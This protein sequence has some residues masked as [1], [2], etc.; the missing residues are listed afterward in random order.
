MNRLFLSAILVFLFSTTESSAQSLSQEDWPWWRGSDRNGIANPDQNPPTEFG[1]EKNCR[2]ST[3]L[4]G[5]SH[6]SA[7][8]VGGKVFLTVAD[9]EKKTQSVLCLDRKT[10][11]QIWNTVVHRNGMTQKSNKKATWASTSPA[12]DGEKVYVNFLAGKA[13]FTTAFD[14]DGN[15]VWQTKISDYVVHQGYG[16]SPAIYKNL[17][18]V[19]ADNKGGGAVCAL[20]RKSG[21][22]IWKN[23]RP[24]EPNYPSPIILKAAG[25]DQLFLTGVDKVSSFDPMTGKT[26]WEIDGATT[27]CV[28]STVTDGERIFTSGGYPKN[29]VA[30]VAADGSG[31]VVWENK[32]RVYVPSMLVKD[33]YLYGVMDAGVAVCWKSA[34]GEEVWK[35]RLGGTFSSSPVLVGDKIYVGSESGEVFVY[36]ATPDGLT[37]VAKNKVAGEIFS[38]PSICGGEIFLRVA[39][40]KGE[41]RTE[42]L[43]CFAEEK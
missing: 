29:H 39:D 27:E 11:E 25:K 22:V 9:V 28:T 18:I 21:K 42:T 7:I 40:Y 13:V 30:A 14:M 10:G 5:R 16:S 35:G 1:P 37:I 19:S 17:V 20:D 3:E 6:G 34:T 36:N 4:P 38:T 32:N 12:C 41:S 8:V 23:K 24:S 33:G 2:W 26:N 43:H 15:Q 31:K